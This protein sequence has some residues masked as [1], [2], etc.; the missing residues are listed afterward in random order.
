MR[1]STENGAGLK[2]VGK[3]R[4]NWGPSIPVEGSPDLSGEGGTIG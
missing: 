4:T 2:T 1:D 3:R